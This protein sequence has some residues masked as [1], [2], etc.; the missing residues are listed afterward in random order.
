MV[1][2]ELSMEC[3]QFYALVDPFF[4]E[5]PGLDCPS[6]RQSTFNELAECRAQ[7]WARPVWVATGQNP[8]IEP[9]R[10]PYIVQL[11]TGDPLLAELDELARDEHQAALDGSTGAMYRLGTLIESSLHPKFVIARLQHMWVYHHRSPTRYLR[12]GDRRVMEFLFN[13]VK[14]ESI[15]DWLGPIKRWHIL[16]RNFEWLS[17]CGAETE[18]TLSENDIFIWQ[19]ILANTAESKPQLK[20]DDT[21]HAMLLQSEAVSLA[22]TQLQ[23]DRTVLDAAVYRRL[24]PALEE[25]AR[26]RFRSPHDSATFLVRYIAD[27][28]C[29]AKQPMQAALALYPKSSETLDSL[30]MLADGNTAKLR[31]PLECETP[32]S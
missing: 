24:P 31:K 5:P 15:V 6:A 16:G 8:L 17:A 20:L 18:V 11:E 23:Q 3:A 14:R 9:H 10:L 27:S 25:T 26:H 12:I 13:I 2:K 28:E 19:S 1:F 22:L 32:G 29:A 21:E 4:G 30:L 7:A